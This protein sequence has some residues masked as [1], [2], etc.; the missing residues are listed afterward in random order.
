[1]SYI[2]VIPQPYVD[3][4]MDTLGSDLAPDTWAAIP[5]WHQSVPV[6]TELPVAQGSSDWKCY[7]MATIQADIILLGKHIA[8]ATDCSNHGAWSRGK[9]SSSWQ[10]AGHQ[11]ALAPFLIFPSIKLPYHEQISDAYVQKITFLKINYWGDWDTKSQTSLLQHVT[12]TINI[13]KCISP[14]PNSPFVSF[15]CKLFGSIKHY[16][17]D[18]PFSLPSLLSSGTPWQGLQEEIR[19]SPF[20][21]WHQEQRPSHCLA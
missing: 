16:K 6:P 9:W 13:T 1:M 11:A 15:G 21:S 5:A 19:Y 4:S 17:A 14:M 20:C 18:T 12:P 8:T 7:A 3:L 10:W 2:P